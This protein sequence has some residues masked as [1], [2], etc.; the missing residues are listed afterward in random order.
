VAATDDVINDV[1]RLANDPRH[2]GNR[3]ALFG[4]LERSADPRA[5]ETLKELSE[6]PTLEYEAKKSLKRL[7]R[8]RGGVAKRGKRAAEE[9]PG[10]L[11]EASM[12]FDSDLVEPFL[13]R[14][15]TL[16]TG[17][18]AKEIAEV[19]QMIAELE[20]DDEREL[21]F[22]VSDEGCWILL[23]VRVFMDDV[24]APD[25]HFFTTPELAKEIEQL[26]AEFREELGA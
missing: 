3:L 23:R 20:V 18:G 22:E 5:R 9:S 17:F 26:L 6:E 1:I 15:S 16:V 12:N 2:G 14:V 11:S 13:Q 24:D 10:G 25:L 4:A 19:A 8:K 7:D 21:R